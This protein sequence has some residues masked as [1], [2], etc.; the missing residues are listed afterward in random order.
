MGKREKIG[1]NHYDDLK[2]FIEYSNYLQDVFKNIEEYNLSKKQKV[3]TIFDDMIAVMINNKKLTL[4]VTELFIRGRK[5]NISIVI[6]T[7]SYSKLPEE[8]RLNT[9]HFFC[10]RELQQIAINHSSDVYFKHFLKIYKNV[11]QNHILFLLR[12]RNYLLKISILY[13]HNYWWSN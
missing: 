3:F 8:V 9:T 7:Q 2:A 4:V 6:L 13:N 1:L 5:L 12:F 10:L 11:Q